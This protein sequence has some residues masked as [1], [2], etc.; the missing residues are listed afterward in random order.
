[1]A[2]SSHELGTARGYAMKKQSVQLVIIDLE[3][4]NRG[5]F[6]GRPLFDEETEPTER[7]VE[8]VWFTDIDNVPSNATLEQVAKLAVRHLESGNHTLQ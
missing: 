2:R 4:G 6:V 8:N 1:M 3:N 7:K 5:V